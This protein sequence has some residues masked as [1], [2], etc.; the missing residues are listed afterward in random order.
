MVGYPAWQT[1]ASVT[2]TILKLWV[3]RNG[4]MSPGLAGLVFRHDENERRC[5]FCGWS[6]AVALARRL[7]FAHV[8]FSFFVTS[9]SL[10][11]WKQCIALGGSVC[12]SVCRISVF[13]C[14]SRF[15]ISVF[16]CL[17]LNPYSNLILFTNP[18]LLLKFF[19]RL[20]LIVQ[21]FAL[22][23]TTDSTKISFKSRWYSL[24]NLIKLFSSCNLLPA[25]KA[26]T[27]PLLSS[28][29]TA[30]TMVNDERDVLL[31]ECMQMSQRHHLCLL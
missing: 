7:Y 17:S 6:R 18:S 19:A 28:L 8:T 21:H 2:V 24:I 4:L 15:L 14:P 16:L 10:P 25:N 29:M 9:S 1:N 13:F 5:R 12:L 31:A 3:G 23:T 22:Y 30:N 11:V 27:R 26:Y 20:F